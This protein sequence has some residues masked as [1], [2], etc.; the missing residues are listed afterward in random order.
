M[1][2]TS[3]SSVQQN[4]DVFFIILERQSVVVT[5]DLLFCTDGEYLLL[6]K[7]TRGIERNASNFKIQIIKTKTTTQQLDQGWCQTIS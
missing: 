3:D 5:M 1:L 6:G 4:F 7:N 2:K